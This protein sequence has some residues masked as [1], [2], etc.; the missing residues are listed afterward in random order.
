MRGASPLASGI[1]ANSTK[2]TVTALGGL[3][4]R[5]RIVIELLLHGRGGRRHRGD[6][7][8]ASDEGSNHGN[9][10]SS[11]LKARARPM[12]PQK[13]PGVVFQT[14]VPEENTPSVFLIA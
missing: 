14:P 9:R 3:D 4:R 2:L 13:T 8:H 5:K 1:V 6:R 11:A 10:T 7:D 12:F